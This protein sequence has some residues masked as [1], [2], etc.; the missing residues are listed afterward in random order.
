MAR[1][2]QALLIALA[3]TV[4]GA[5]VLAAPAAPYSQDQLFREFS[6]GLW[7][8]M[9]PISIEKFETVTLPLTPEWRTKKEEQIKRRAEGKQ[10]FTSDSRCIPAGM[11][12][13]MLN[14]AFEVLVRPNSI[15]LITGGGGMQIRNI[16]T[17]GRKHTPVDDLFETFSGEPIGTWEGDTLVVTTIGLRPSNEILY[18][19]QGHAMTVTE[20]FRKTEPDVLEVK[21]TVMDPVVFATPWSFTTN[22]K[23][24]LGGAITEN[25]YCVAALDRSVNQDGV[26]TMD[27]TPPPDPR[28]K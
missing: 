1:S 12:R 27:L 24:Q 18:G 6:G 3:L 14:A 5:P 8:N 22:Y 4:A 7:R 9:N 25:N 10:V 16:W 15:A 17:D 23:R 21:T 26:E 20:R 2:S 11:P 28:G 19:V 13:M